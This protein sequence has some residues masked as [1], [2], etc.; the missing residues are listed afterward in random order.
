MV[1]YSII[2]STFIKMFCLK[3]G[4]LA[5]SSIFLSTGMIYYFSLLFKGIEIRDLILTVLIES[6]FLFLFMIFTGIDFITGIQASFHFNR[7][8]KNPLPANKVIKSSKLWRTFWKSFGVS[9]LTVM[10][11]FLA[12]ISTVMDSAYTHWVF[13][14][15][16]ICF[17]IMACGFEFYS[18]GENLAI[19]NNGSKPMI[20]GF[21]DK[22][23]DAIQRKTIDKIDDSFNILEK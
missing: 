18:I 12:L 23:L 4:S 19:R 9:M 3:K 22:V 16:L 6:V 1:Y 5:L 7:N 15:A 11:T 14:W 21:V 10:L 13:L 17:W 8:S 20:F 2:T